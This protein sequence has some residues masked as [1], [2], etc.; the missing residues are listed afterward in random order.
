MHSLVDWVTPSAHTL[1]LLSPN[2]PNGFD[3]WEGFIAVLLLA[4]FK[5]FRGTAMQRRAVYIDRF[6]WSII[7]YDYCFFVVFFVSCLFTLYPQLER[8]EW[9]ARILL[10]ILIAVTIWQF[11]EVRW[12]S[13][14]RIQHATGPEDS[15]PPPWDRHERR[16]NPPRREEDRRLRSMF[17]VDMIEP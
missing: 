12:A 6:G 1:S 13:T 2:W 4:A 16:V 5:L 7:V 17:K 15:T 10:A 14:R 11:A 8:S 9:I 3:Q